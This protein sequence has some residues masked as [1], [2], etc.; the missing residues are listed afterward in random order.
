MTATNKRYLTTTEVAAELRVSTDTVLRLIQSGT[1][2]A[3]RVSERLYRIP[4]PAFARFIAGPVD[5][6]RVE[7]QNIDQIDD[8]GADEGVT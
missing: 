6:R 4:A 1:L 8:F 5:R 3:L 2:P 7:Y